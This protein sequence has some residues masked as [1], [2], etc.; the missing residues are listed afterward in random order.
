MQIKEI[1][2]SEEISQI[3]EFFAKNCTDFDAKTHA[4]HISK[5]IDHGCKIAASLDDDKKYS[6]VI[7]AK[8]YEKFQ[9]GKVFEIEDFS[10]TKND[11]FKASNALIEWA[12]NQAKISNCANVTINII[13]K[14]TALQKIFSQQKF[15]L[16]SFCFK[17][18]LS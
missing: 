9:Q 8:I 6:G 11:D 13:T 12:Q 3:A 4:K 10:L 5:M 2:N 15:T 18:H 7:I 1:R 14:N 17:A 16:D